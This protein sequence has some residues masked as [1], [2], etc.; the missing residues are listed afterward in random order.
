MEITQPPQTELHYKFNFY[1]ANK[2][3]H[4]DLENLL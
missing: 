3:I 1:K 4:L 2:D